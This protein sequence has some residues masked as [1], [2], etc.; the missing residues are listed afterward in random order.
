MGLAGSFGALLSVWLVVGLAR[1]LGGG[2][3]GVSNAR[4]PKAPGPEALPS[5]GCHLKLLC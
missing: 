1:R 2:G 4:I 3:G 5:K